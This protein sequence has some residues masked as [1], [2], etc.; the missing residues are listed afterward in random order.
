MAKYTI[1]DDTLPFT[2]VVYQ[3]GTPTIEAGTIFYTTPDNGP[4]DGLRCA[5]GRVYIPDNPLVTNKSI[6]MRAYVGSF[7]QGTTAYTNDIVTAVPVREAVTTTPASGGW[8]E[9]LW[10]T[11]FVTDYGPVGCYIAVCYE[12]TDSADAGV[13]VAGSGL[14]PEA[15][16]SASLGDTLRLA[17]LD[18]GGGTGASWR[19][20]GQYVIGT[21]GN[22]YPAYYCTDI[23]MDDVA[24]PGTLLPVASYGFNEGSGTMVADS[25][26]NGWNITT[27]TENFVADGYTQAG[28]TARASNAASLPSVVA[29][30]SYTALTLA[31]DYQLTAMFWGRRDSADGTGWSIGQTESSG[32]TPYWG[33]R[34]SDGESCVFTLYAGGFPAQVLVDH[35]PIGEWHHYAMSVTPYGSHCYIDG[36]LVGENSFK[37]SY[38]GGANLMSYNYGTTIDDVRLFNHALSGAAVAHYMGQP[39]IDGG[40][41]GKVKHWTGSEWQAHPVKVWDGDAWQPRAINATEDGTNFITGRG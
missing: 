5:G 39:I 27:V 30:G 1:F 8:C 38:D 19:Y 36:V 4:A 9:V 18:N 28:I 35:Q 33:I 40:R 13:Y 20:R 32:V 2:P 25:T 24:A 34:L 16:S 41:S 29:I 7:F 26:G 12:F 21:G 3:D 14:P 11:P 17:E 23:I 6:T 15:I 22:S 37:A 31:T 10:D